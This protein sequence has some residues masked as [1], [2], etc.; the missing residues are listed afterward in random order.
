MLA[1]GEAPR[2][3]KADLLGVPL[4][5]LK[6]EE[7]LLLLIPCGRV[8][9]RV[10]TVPRGSFLRPVVEVAER[11]DERRDERMDTSE[12]SRTSKPLPHGA[13]RVATTTTTTTTTHG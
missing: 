12:V 6:L 1:K 2:G 5:A 9:A 13:R 8:G 3:F 7:G 10:L 11:G 4:A